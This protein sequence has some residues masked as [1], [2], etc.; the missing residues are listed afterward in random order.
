MYLFSQFF[1]FVNY[2]VS[3]VSPIHAGWFWVGVRKSVS[4]PAHG[5]T[6]ADGVERFV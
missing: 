1:L 6:I 3:L 2:I 4:S 5:N